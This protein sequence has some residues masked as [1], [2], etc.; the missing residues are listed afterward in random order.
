MELMF[1]KMLRDRLMILAAC[2]FVIICV[3]VASQIS[4]NKSDSVVAEAQDITTEKYIKWVDFSVPYNALKD[5]MELDI[6]TYASAKHLP[7]IDTISFLSCKN[8]G[9]W[10]GY[11]TSQLDKLTEALQG[12]MTVDDLMKTNKY[13]SFYKEAY[14]AVLG[15]M[16]GEY[17]KASPDGNGGIKI[18][19]GYGLKA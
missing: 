3:L 6:S 9:N 5:A 13:Y 1:L 11:K 16:L 7:W 18:V 14:S 17:T 19:E 8:G 15:G 12:D 2:G 4:G 10:S